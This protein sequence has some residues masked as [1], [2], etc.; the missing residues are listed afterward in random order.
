MSRIYR[1]LGGQSCSPEEVTAR[2][3][4]GEQCARE[5]LELFACLLATVAADLALVF[6]AHGGV[7]LA[8]GIV[9]ANLSL[10]EH[11]GFRQR[12]ETKG[13]YRSYLANIPCWVITAKNPSFLGLHHL[14]SKPANRVS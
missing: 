8:G 6:G 13:R 2:A 7:Y 4:A 14:L 12:F 10:F 1:H 3:D 5:T 9:P 11:S